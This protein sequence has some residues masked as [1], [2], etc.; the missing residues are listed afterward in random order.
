MSILTFK[1]GNENISIY[2]KC[3]NHHTNFLSS[4][5]FWPSLSTIFPPEWTLLIDLL[6]NFRYGLYEYHLISDIH[7]GKNM[8][9]FSFQVE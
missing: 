5:Q 4:G 6:L 8:S 2:F 7:T 3:Q 9:F 1:R